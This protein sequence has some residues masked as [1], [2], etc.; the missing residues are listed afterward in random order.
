[1]P[2]NRLWMEHTQ[3]GSL[4]RGWK[5]KLLSGILYKCVSQNTYTCMIPQHSN[6]QTDDLTVGSFWIEILRS[7]SIIVGFI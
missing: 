1:V 2:E 7:R 4:T 5:D 3:G 6:T